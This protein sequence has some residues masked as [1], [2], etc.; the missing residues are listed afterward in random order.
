[1]ENSESSPG[2]HFREND[3]EPVT[4]KERIIALL[5]GRIPLPQV[6]LHGVLHTR[7]FRQNL[8]R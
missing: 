1:M 6:L 4:F 3:H 8:V 5:P 7:T 2:A